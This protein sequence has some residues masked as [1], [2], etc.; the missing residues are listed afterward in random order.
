MCR[1]LTEGRKTENG[2]ESP[3]PPHTFC[4]IDCHIGKGAT[5]SRRETTLKVSLGVSE[6][7]RRSRAVARRTGFAARV[8]QTPGTSAA[9]AREEE[10]SSS[11]F[12][13]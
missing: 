10:A 2:R 8:R 4:V 6:F 11:C 7:T 3:P 1:R 13:S 12:C 5:T 9:A